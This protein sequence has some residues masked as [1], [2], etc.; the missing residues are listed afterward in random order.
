MNNVIFFHIAKI[1]E[2]YQEI[3]DEIF[4]YIFDSKLIED[5][6]YIFISILGTGEFNFPIHNKIKIIFEN[7]D[8]NLLEFPTLLLLKDFAK[9]NINY[10]I[11]YLH[12]KGVSTNENEIKNVD[13]WRRYMLYFNITRYKDCLKFLKEY[14]TCGVDLHSNPVLHYSG[15][16][17]WGTSNYIKNLPEFEYMPTI[18][19]NRHKA[20]FWICY[21]KTSK[22]KAMWEA[23]VNLYSNDYTENFYKK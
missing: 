15:N 22:H 12:S 18:I 9:N 6:E 3:V 10:N 8:L 7:P 13:S 21:N 5:I 23:N 20:E 2:R 4:S 14:D 16:F 11:L 19:S 17:W 1:G